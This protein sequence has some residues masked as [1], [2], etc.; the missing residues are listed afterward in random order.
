[1]S[2]RACRRASHGRPRGREWRSWGC[3]E[4][5]GADPGCMGSRWCV[6]AQGPCFPTGHSCSSRGGSTAGDAV[7]KHPQDPQ[8][9]PLASP[10]VTG[11]RTGPEAGRG[12]PIRA[13][14]SSCFQGGGYW[15]AQPWL[16][17]LSQ[18]KYGTATRCGGEARALVGSWCLTACLTPGPLSGSEV[19]RF[20]SYCPSHVHAGHQVRRYARPLQATPSDHLAPSWVTPSPGESPGAHPRGPPCR[21]STPQSA[22]AQFSTTI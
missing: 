5:A 9:L 17:A 19:T 7:G 3:R 15:S 4:R 18:V 16:S 13:A 8:C 11:S 21:T 10:P 14:E 22:R 6:R 1:M 20:G 12:T 2:S